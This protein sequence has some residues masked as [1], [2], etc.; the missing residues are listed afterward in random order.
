MPAS[1]FGGEYLHSDLYER[2]AAYLFHLV[3]NHAFID[4]NKRT[5]TVAALVFLEL[6]G[7]EVDADDAEFEH[8]VLDVIE[9]KAAKSTV[10]EYF[11]RNSKP[12]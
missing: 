2:A 9:N 12:A 1:T 5:G 10:A 3:K 11:R 6:N 4:E 8:L 7:I